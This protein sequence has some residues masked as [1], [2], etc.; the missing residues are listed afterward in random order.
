MVFMTG[1]LYVNEDRKKQKAKLCNEQ[2][3]LLCVL[4][5]RQN[6]ENNIVHLIL[7]TWY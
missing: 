5:A 6:K 3:Y 7:T 4:R 2:M 1:Y